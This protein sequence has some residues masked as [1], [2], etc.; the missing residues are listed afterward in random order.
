MGLMDMV[1]GLLGGQSAQGDSKA[2]LIQAAIGM[3]QN[4]PG[5]LQGLL[6]QFQQAGLAQH[7]ES[8]VGSGANQ[9]LT[10]D[11]VQ[12]ALSGDQL[13]AVAQG[14]GM[15][16]GQASQGLA[17]LL[18]EIVNHLTPNGGMPDASALQQGLGGLLGKFL[19]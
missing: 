19:G 11:H 14:A 9:A 18:P 16:P 4:H 17:S 5:G 3:I 12:Q 2:A 13:Q 15:D 6:G 1:G 10:A 7:V 8:W